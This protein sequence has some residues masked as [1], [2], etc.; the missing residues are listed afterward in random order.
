MTKCHD[1]GDLWR[2]G[3]LFGFM[4]QEDKHHCHSETWAAGKDDG[5]NA[6]S[7]PSKLQAACREQTEKGTSL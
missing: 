3:L 4:V 5:R 6:E 1:H 2:E 7:S